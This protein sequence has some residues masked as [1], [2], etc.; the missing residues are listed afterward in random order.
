M[1]GF[2]GLKWVQPHF[3]IKKNEEVIDK[4]YLQEY[5]YI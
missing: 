2:K 3:V 1:S 5:K 4:E